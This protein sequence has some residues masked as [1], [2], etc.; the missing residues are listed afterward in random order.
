LSIMDGQPPNDVLRYTLFSSWPDEPVRGRPAEVVTDEFAEF[1]LSQFNTRSVRDTRAMYLQFPGTLNRL[2][3]L[4]HRIAY[5]GSS[6][7]DVPPRV[8]ADRIEQ[9]LR[10]S[11]EYTYSLKSETVNDKLDPV[12]DFLFERKQGDCKYFAS[13]L[14]LMLRTVG[15]PT[16]IINGFKGGE[17]SNVPGELLVQQ[18]HAHTWVEALIADDATE[19]SPP[20]LSWVVYD[21]TP[22]A[23]DEG[24]I[25][26]EAGTSLWETMTKAS[27]ELWSNYIVQMSLN[28]QTQDIYAP[29][30]NSAREWWTGSG[31]A[32]GVLAQTAAGLLNFLK[33]PDQWVSWKGGLI[34]F[35]LMA[36]LAGSLW[37]SRRIWNLMKRWKRRSDNRRNAQTIRIE[38][39]ERFLALLSRYGWKRNPSQTQREFAEEFIGEFHRRFPEK[40]LGDLPRSITTN[41]YQC[42][43]GLQPLSDDE[44]Q[45]MQQNLTRLE[46]VLT[47]PANGNGQR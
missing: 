43:F 30:Q 40:S 14:A 41:F 33:H 2:S 5:R 26:V 19:S 34:T 15:V 39:Y 35:S 24:L 37:I 45:T 29:I 7:D 21:P 10:N 46:A 32:R 23:R 13:S 47:Q 17:T 36:G 1:F 38:F 9:F 11:G 6:I 42:R 28:R 27:Q 22:A 16:R 8:R 25:D 3:E 18:R 20:R 44:I 31:G 4:A 12:E